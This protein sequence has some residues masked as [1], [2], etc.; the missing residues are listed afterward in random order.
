M[1][2]R[3]VNL[4][5]LQLDRCLVEFGD[6]YW[7]DSDEQETILFYEFVGMEWQLEFDLRSQLKCITLRTNQSWVMKNKGSLTALPSH[8]RRHR[9]RAR[10]RWPPRGGSGVFVNRRVLAGLLE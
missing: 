3:P 4:A 9:K 6:F 5:A 8:G 2:G 1:K 10:K 7:R